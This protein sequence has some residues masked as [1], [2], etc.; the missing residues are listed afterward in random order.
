[1]VAA[2]LAFLPTYSLMLWIEETLPFW[3]HVDGGQL[4]R[5]VFVVW[6]ALEVIFFLAMRLLARMLDQP[7]QP[8]PCDAHKVMGRFISVVDSIR[9][10][11]PVERFLSVWCGARD[12][13]E[14]RRQ[15]YEEFMSW[16]VTGK[17]RTSLTGEHKLVVEREVRRH[18]VV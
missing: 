18:P 13:S 1:M 10:V 12:F 2:G 8:P 14:V 7:T 3:R 15:N 16:V 4:W 9:D 17:E 5:L 11:F 6:M